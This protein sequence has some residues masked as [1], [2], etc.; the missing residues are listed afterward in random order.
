M[1]KR[2]TENY[3]G[4]EKKKPIKKVRIESSHQQ[5]PPIIYLSNKPGVTDCLN[6]SQKSGGGGGNE[7]LDKIIIENTFPIFLVLLEEN[8]HVRKILKKERIEE[9]LRKCIILSPYEL[10]LVNPDI[11]SKDA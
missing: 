5:Q 6:V 4:N 10:N 9:K 8:I 2:E 11:F 1:L 7:I 3:D